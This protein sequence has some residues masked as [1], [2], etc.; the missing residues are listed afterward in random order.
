MLL[1][2]YRAAG[3]DMSAVCCI[4]ATAP[5]IRQEDLERGLATLEANNWRFV[6]SATTFPYPIFR[7]FHQNAGGGLQ[8]VFPGFF[9]ARSQDLREAWHDAGQFYWATPRT[10]LSKA[11]VFDEH[12]T[13]IHIPRWRVQDI[14]TEEDW[15][16]A[17]VMATY[18][19][20]PYVNCTIGE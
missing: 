9:S 6:F 17:E 2:G 14:D 3:L 4:Y 20:L 12:S 15:A 7:S 1:I 11:R 13:F 10:W 19:G 18:L 8:M 16:R 5:F